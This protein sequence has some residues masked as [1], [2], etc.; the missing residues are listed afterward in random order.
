MVVAPQA[1]VY[2]L[3]AWEVVVVVVAVPLVVD[4][5]APAAL[6]VG[7]VVVLAHQVAAGLEV[8][9]ANVEEFHLDATV[10]QDRLHLLHR[11]EDVTLV[12]KVQWGN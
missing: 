8:M 3:G 2:L 11:W 1:L 9:E 4:A 5:V 7:M 10:V 6:L 12:V